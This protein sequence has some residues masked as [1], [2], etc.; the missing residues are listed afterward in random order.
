MDDVGQVTMNSTS[1]P[2][3]DSLYSSSVVSQKGEEGENSSTKG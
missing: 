3:K 2:W 1:D